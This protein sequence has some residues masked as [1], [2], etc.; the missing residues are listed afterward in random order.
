MLYGIQDLARNMLGVR[1]STTPQL[2][3]TTTND[4]L[5]RD[6]FWAVQNVNFD[7]K[8]GE[9]LGI[10]GMNGSGKST[11]LRILTG[12]FPPDD[13]QVVVSGRLSGLIALGA[14]FHP[15]MTGR[16]NIYLNGAILGIGRDEIQNKFNAIVDFANI[17]DFLD[18]PVSTYSSGMYVRLGF[19]IAIH[20]LS[21]VVVIDEIL[22]VGDARFQRKCLDHIRELRKEGRSFILVSH[23]MQ[24]IEAMCSRVLF[25]DHGHSIRLG[26]AAEVIPEYEL[27]QMKGSQAETAGERP[28]LNP[29]G[30]QHLV[31]YKEFG[32]DEVTINGILLLDQHG[33][34]QTEFH[35]ND[36]ATVQIALCARQE[37]LDAYLWLAFV[38]VVDRV[39]REKDVVCVGVRTQRSIPKGLVTIDFPFERL[40]F[41]TGE[42]KINFCIFDD[43]FLNPYSQGFYGYFTVKNAIPTML[44]V[45]SGVPFFWLQPDVT[46]NGC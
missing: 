41:A 5:R 27:M 15:H 16:E 22:A 7:L 31:S 32:T 29:A 40:Q 8:R 33:N 37:L 39:D 34:P 36:S 1:P 12:I 26:P 43:T 21:D 42:Y 45:G 4:G 28:K 11:L 35:A 19:A 3:N 44:R 17:G 20:S 14:G 6:E 30:L 13:G 23:N 38:H 2:D 46:I 24:N 10:I 9:I 25:L 18:A